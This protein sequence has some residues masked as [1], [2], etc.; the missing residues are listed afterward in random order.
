MNRL[1]RPMF[2]IV[3]ILMLTGAFL[4]CEKNPA[5]E[6]SKLTEA[7]PALPKPGDIVLVEAYESFSVE[8]V[9]E[10]II[11]FFDG[12]YDHPPME[13][14]VNSYRVR[15]VTSDFDGSPAVAYAQL[16][17]PQFPES[18]EL[19]TYVF[20]SGTTGITDR[21]AP[22]LEDPWTIRWGWY[23]Q[24]ML[25]YAGSGYITIFPDY[26]GFNDPTISQRY[27]SK[28]AEAHVMLD[29]IRAVENLYKLSDSPLLNETARPSGKN[30]VAGYSQ[31]GHAA[32]AAADLNSAYAPDVDV[33]GVIGYASTNDI[34]ALF[35]EG[36]CYGA[37]IIYSY[38]EMYGWDTVNPADFLNDSYLPTFMEDAST[39]SVDVF[40][41][42]FGYNAKKLFRPEFYNALFDG[43][44]AENY[45]VMNSY[46]EQNNSGL[47]GHGKPVFQVQGGTD[48]IITTASQDIFIKRLK[49]LGSEVDYRVYDG[50]SHKYSRMA[51]F[52][53]TLTWMAEHE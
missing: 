17:V 25:A 42:H 4:G 6:S 29:A 3:V 11:P 1:Y 8:E 39:M 50:V 20:G 53:D 19:S 35:R 15:F 37:E 43:T 23:K 32:H 47:S 5:V 16:F 7:G 31:G 44:L 48:F 34:A 21:A 40:Q 51:G 18:T 38:G 33:T 52:A 12:K 9:E 46:F 30:F 14:G 36:V 49:D 45:P 28:D 22:S 27:F 24:N 10:A 2:K 26:I 13:Y 41:Y